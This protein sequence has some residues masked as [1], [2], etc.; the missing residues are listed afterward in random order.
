MQNTIMLYSYNVTATSYL[1][2][3]VILLTLSFRFIHYLSIDTTFDMV[4]Y[5][6]VDIVSLN[7]SLPPS[8]YVLLLVIQGY[9]ELN[10]FTKAVNDR[11]QTTGFQ[12]C[13]VY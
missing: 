2:V 1:Y 4:C 11:W 13:I 12:R 8:L 5:N 9:A 10:Y 7:V 3:S 6:C